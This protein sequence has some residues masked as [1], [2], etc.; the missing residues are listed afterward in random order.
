MALCI[1]AKQ[2][3][4][5]QF[6]HMDRNGDR[7]L[8]FSEFRDLLRKGKSPVTE[9]Q[10]WLMFACADKSHDGVLDFEEFSHFAANK[11]NEKLLA[12]L[13]NPHDTCQEDVIRL[14]GKAPGAL[15]STQPFRTRAQ[16]DASVTSKRSH[17]GPTILDGTGFEHSLR[18]SMHNNG[19]T[20]VH[21]GGHILN[22]TCPGHVDS[23]LSTTQEGWAGLSPNRSASRPCSR[24]RSSSRPCSRGSQAQSDCPGDFK[25]CSS[26]SRS[27]SR[28][29]E[30]YGP[31]R[32]F[33]DRSTFT[34]VHVHGGPSAIDSKGF[35]S[36]MR[37]SH[38][39]GSTFT[40]TAGHPLNQDG[41]RHVF[42]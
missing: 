17:R 2:D 12:Q 42:I 31:E 21:S 16:R 14:P 22:H 9:D 33:Y 27:S 24:S 8:D 4:R 38:N 6:S 3:I 35:S 19:S 30:V 37:P 39:C 10:L 36:S 13:N 25:P 40:R 7:C 32:F 28:V 1:D 26:R 20:F 11:R 15:P 34:G 18:D 23:Y 29:Q 41:A 5:D